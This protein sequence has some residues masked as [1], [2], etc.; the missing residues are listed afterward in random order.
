MKKKPIDFKFQRSFYPYSDRDGPAVNIKYKITDTSNLII[1][2][3]LV[4]RVLEFGYFTD[5]RT[6]TGNGAVRYPLNLFP[7]PK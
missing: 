5:M 3:N 2:R 7:I 4:D 1:D 6:N